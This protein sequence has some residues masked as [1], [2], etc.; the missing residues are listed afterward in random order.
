[1]SKKLIRLVLLSAIAC[2]LCGGSARAQA[3]YSDSGVPKTVSLSAS[4]PESLSIGTITNGSITFTLT[5]TGNAAGSAVPS[6]TTSWVLNA[7]RNS[8]D[9]CVYFSSS[10]ALTDGAGNNIPTS[11]FEA[12]PGGAGGT[13]GAVTGGPFCGQTNAKVISSTT[14]T[15]AN[16]QSSKGDSVGLRINETA[17][18]QLPAATYTGTLNVL[19]MAQ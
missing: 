7:S 11:S 2:L 5:G 9:V 17:I 18:G 14:I 8:V 19:A 10:N 15:G 13:Y 16:K 4:K 3:I 12:A 6:W 1:M